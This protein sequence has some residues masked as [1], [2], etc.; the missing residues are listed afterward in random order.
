M[1]RAPA[2][3]SHALLAALALPALPM[4]ALT[5]P[6]IIY[7]PEFFAHS[8]GLN[9]AMVGFIFTVVRLADL[10]FDPFV[11][12][13]MDRTRT[14]WGQFRPWL[15]LGGPLVMA[16]TWMLFM[17]RPGV[18][19]LYLSAGLVLAYVGYSMVVLSQMGMGAAI[20]PDYRGRSR[21][22]AWWMVC[23]TLG[24]ILVMAMPVFFADRIA[25]DSSFTV[26]TMGWFILA[27]VPVTIAVTVLVVREGDAPTPAHTARLRDYLGLFR[28]SSTR[29]LLL[30]QLLVGLGLGIS[31]AVFLFFFTMLKQVPFAYVGLQFVAFYVVGVA[32]APVWSMIANRIGRHR[33]L[34]IGCCGFAAYMVLM[35][36]M[37]P[38]NMVY[39]FGMGLLGGT[40]ACS[41]DML[42]RSMMADVSDE[43]RLASGQDRTGM[44]FALLTVTHKFGQAMSIGVVYFALDLIGFKAGSPTNSGAALRGVSVLY[45]VVPGV[46]YIASALVVSRFG[47]TPARH[48]AIRKELAAL[49]V[50]DVA[51]DLPP[52]VLRDEGGAGVPLP[53]A[54]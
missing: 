14:R 44:L 10:L 45:G 27:S 37:P 39:F 15:L 31:A 17:A 19:P 18:G 25:H 46:L 40:M 8:L 5:L 24:Q 38:G 53:L 41:V 30:T 23:N 48:D 33:A 32:T 20:A 11:G 21:V 12:G 28:L 42:P 49:G 7:L 54:T 3:P 2:H 6:L 1:A 52:E 34:A 26:R 43:D 16:G 35:M 50:T 9:L 22:F 51:G 47:L 29:L 36:A 13:L 4:S